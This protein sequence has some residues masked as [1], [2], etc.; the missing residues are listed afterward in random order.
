MR[1]TKKERLL[2]TKP[3]GKFPLGQVVVTAGVARAMAL[4]DAERGDGQL[5]GAAVAETLAR[6]ELGDWGDVGDEDKQVN[7][8]ALKNGERLLSSYVV[9]QDKTGTHGTPEGTRIWII[10]EADRSATTVLF[11]DEY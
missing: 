5:Y 7:E 1:D 2:R 3:A 6:H 10:T 9:W 8:D 4:A 11:P